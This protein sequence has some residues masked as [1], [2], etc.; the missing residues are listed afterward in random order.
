MK[1]ILRKCHC[2][3]VD[4]GTYKNTVQMKAPFYVKGCDG[5]IKAHSPWVCIDTCIATAIGFLW[6][7]GIITLNSCCG[8]GKISA[9][10]IVDDDSVQD[11]IDMGYEFNTLKN[12]L[13]EFLI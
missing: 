4:F 5:K 3:D 7:Q 8:H 11:M 12:N 9:S 2:V 6:H 13:K 10:V 1:K